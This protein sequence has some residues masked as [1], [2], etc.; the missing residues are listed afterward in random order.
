MISRGCILIDITV[1]R[2]P[3]GRGGI[4]ISSLRTFCQ[5]KK[6]QDLFVMKRKYKGAR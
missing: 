5:E 6:I 1:I 4:D 3:E 2:D